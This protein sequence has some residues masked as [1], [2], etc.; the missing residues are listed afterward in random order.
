MFLSLR[1]TIWY[2]SASTNAAVQHK[3]RIQA[4]VTLI[5]RKQFLKANEYAKLLLPWLDVLDSYRK[6]YLRPQLD[7][8]FKYL[9]NC[10]YQKR[11]NHRFGKHC[12]AH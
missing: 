3:N 11:K 4:I 9:Q 6:N 8:V 10:C 7:D 5:P 1:T 2:F 12:L